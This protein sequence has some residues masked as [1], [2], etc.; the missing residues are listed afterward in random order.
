M[1]MKKYINNASALLLLG[2]G[3]YFLYRFLVIIPGL[4]ATFDPSRG[5]LYVIILGVF[6]ITTA[7]LSFAAIGLL[8]GKNWAIICGWT[9]VL[10]PQVVKFIFPFGIIPLRDSGILLIINVILLIYVTTQ[11]GKL[12]AE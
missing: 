12:K 3:V 6:I 10:L 1:Q 2:E 4:I 5:F 8:Q 11:W 9:A 7:L